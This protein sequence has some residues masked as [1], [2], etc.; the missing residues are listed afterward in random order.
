M[1]KSDFIAMVI[2]IL[3]VLLIMLMTCTHPAFGAE[4]PSCDE[5]RPFNGCWIETKWQYDEC[6]VQK[7]EAYCQDGKWS[8]TGVCYVTAMYCP[9]KIQV[10]PISDGEYYGRK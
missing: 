4:R 9:R 10:D 6:N 5:C 3:L 8:Y 2:M 1:R 7:C